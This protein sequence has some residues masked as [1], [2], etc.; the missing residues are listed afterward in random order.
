MSPGRAVAASS[1]GA[2]SPF[3][4]AKW[5]AKIQ[6]QEFWLHNQDLAASLQQSAADAQKWDSWMEFMNPITVGM[7][8]EDTSARLKQSK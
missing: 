6:E 1:A 7:A 4:E 8:A 2:P 5:I 3:T